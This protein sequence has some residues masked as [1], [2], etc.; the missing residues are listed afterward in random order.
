IEFLAFPIVDRHV[1]AMN[2]ETTAFLQTLSN[3]YESGNTIVIH[4]RLGVGR[5]AL[6]AASLLAMTGMP[7]DVAFARIEQVRG[8][9]VPDTPEQHMWV[10]L[11]IDTYIRPPA[12]PEEFATVTEREGL[13]EALFENAQR[14]GEHDSDWPEEGYRA[15][16]EPLLT[17]D[18]LAEA[19]KRGVDIETLINRW[20]REKLRETT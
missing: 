10:K 2:A 14:S 9:R 5:S 6:V 17:R 3:R 12:V 13:W 4:C 8:C 15:T 7:E 16:L 11:F 19:E 1:P 20:L 18:L